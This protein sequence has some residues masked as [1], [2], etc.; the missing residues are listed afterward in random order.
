MTLVF[1]G[2]DPLK[3]AV[4]ADLFDADSK[5]VLNGF[6]DGFKHN[7]SGVGKYV[8][9]SFFYSDNVKGLSPFSI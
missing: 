3:F 9:L 8:F 7:F 5:V 6:S 4:T 2:P 1:D